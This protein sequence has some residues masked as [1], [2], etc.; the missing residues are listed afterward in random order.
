MS[1]AD[2][3]DLLD[4][5]LADSLSGDELPELLE[6]LKKHEN[7]AALKEAIQQALKENA[8]KDLSDRS[9]IDIVFSK[10]MQQAEN[11]VPE[12]GMAVLPRRRTSFVLLRWAAAAAI[13]VAVLSGAYYF[14]N[15]KPAP[16]IAAEK[17][18]R[19][20]FTVDI[21]PGGNKAI[22]QLADSTSIVLDNTGTGLLA[23]QGNTKV[24]Q[25]DNGQL[26]YNTAS[27]NNSAM[28]YNTVSTP[29][30]GQYQVVLP[31]G[32][33]VWLN[34]ASSLRFPTAFAGKERSVTLTGEAYFEIAHNKTMPFKVRVNEVEVDVLGTH[35]D[36][37]SYKDE[38]MT[39]T[40][41]LEGAV[42]VSSLL[43]AGDAGHGL[44]I[45]PGEQA[46][47]RQNASVFTVHEADIESVVAWKNGL[48]Q[49]SSADIQTIM[50]Q[51][52]RWFDVNVHYQGPVPDGHYSGTVGR[53]TSLLTVLKILEES[54]VKFKLEGNELTVL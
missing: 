2:F 4:R 48:F 31:D 22:L 47:I 49:F 3:K 54:G 1:N 33:R 16:L 21:A 50:R 5:Y 27:G 25:L 15:Y 26:T 36:V 44:L 12:A 41:L 20:G 43:A 51:I 18:A 38:A 34:A 13:L 35:F 23:Q 24:L 14:I 45:R 42:R 32:S 6:Y 30:G 9:R 40:T 39:S 8:Y 7:S 29:R 19:P 10:I 17:K 11:K 46:S 53:N 52:E 28:L 37:M